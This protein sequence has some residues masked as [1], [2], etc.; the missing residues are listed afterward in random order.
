MSFLGKQKYIHNS[1]KL[2]EMN[3]QLKRMG[4]DVQSMTDEKFKKYNSLSK[5]RDGIAA[6][7]KYDEIHTKPN[8][9]KV[10]N[11]TT[12]TDSFKN[13][14]D[15]NTSVPITAITNVNTSKKTKSVK[16]ETKKSKKK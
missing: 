1:K 15:I 3:R 16:P 6:G 12:I 11:N 4:T 10:N 13:S 5:K 7:L 14:R 2:G 8:K 9:T